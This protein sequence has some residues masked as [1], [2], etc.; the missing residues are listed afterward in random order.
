MPASAVIPAAIAYVKVV[1]VK[2]HVVVF[3][4]RMLACKSFI[5]LVYKGERL[6]SSSSSS[7][8][9]SKGVFCYL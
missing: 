8:C 3:L 2:K 4:L 9:F 7:C 6:I 5:I 1:A